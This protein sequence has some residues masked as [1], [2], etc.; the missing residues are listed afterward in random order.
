M[1]IEELTRKPGTRREMIPTGKTFQ[2]FTEVKNYC[3][4]Y[5]EN[6]KPL[7]DSIGARFRIVDSNEVIEVVIGW[8]PDG[9]A[10]VLESFLCYNQNAV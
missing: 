3:L 10:Y 8:Y 5:A 7:R 2:S 4:Q 9:E 1:I 6:M